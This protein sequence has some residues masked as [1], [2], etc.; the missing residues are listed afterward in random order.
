MRVNQGLFDIVV[1]VGSDNAVPLAHL[2]TTG[3]PAS[4][5]AADGSHLPRRHAQEPGDHGDA[6]RRYRLR[7]GGRCR[8]REWRDRAVGRRQCGRRRGRPLWRRHRRARPRSRRQLRDRRRNRPLRPVR[9]SR[10][11]TSAPR[12]P[13][14]SL[15]FPAGR[16]PVRPRS[17][18]IRCA[19]A[20][21]STC[22]AMPWSRPRRSIRS[23]RRCQPD[24]RPAARIFT[25]DGG[26]IHIVGTA[27][28]DASARGLI[29]AGGDSRLGHRRQ[30]RRQARPSAPII[31]DGALD[32]PRQWRRR[33]AI[34]P[35]R[36]RSAA[37][38]LAATPASS[39]RTAAASPPMAASRSMPNG[40]GSASNGAGT[41]NGAAGRGGNVLVA[42]AAAA[43]S[44]SPAPQRERTANGRRRAERARPDRRPRPGRHRHDPLAGRKGRLQRQCGLRRRGHRRHGAAGG[45]ARAATSSSR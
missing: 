36:S 33:Q 43:S 28:V 42:A 15:D 16:Q 20:R 1:D 29:D 24:R 44:I 39:L 40:T 17:A 26:T 3:G 14:G 45:A 30:R 2:G 7:S 8:R 22:M 10:A 38:A 11:P 13:A 18:T 41:V 31:V 37:R 5:G 35:R 32:D 6:R 34:R 21:R 9:R 25:Q 19:A 12:P 4:A 27:T 23:I